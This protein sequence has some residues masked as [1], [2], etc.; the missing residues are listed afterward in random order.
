MPADNWLRP[1]TG[2]V[3]S[4]FIHPGEQCLGKCHVANAGFKILAIRVHRPTINLLPRTNS[5]LIFRPALAPCGH[6]L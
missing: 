2:C 6:P 1:F 5:R 4:R 3:N